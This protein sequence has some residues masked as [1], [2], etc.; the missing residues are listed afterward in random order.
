[1]YSDFMYHHSDD[2]EEHKP[3]E[4]EENA[5]L[6]GEEDANRSGKEDAN[7]SGEEDTNE[8]GYKAEETNEEDYKAGEEYKPTF[9]DLAHY[10]MAVEL[11][12]YGYLDLAVAVPRPMPPQRERAKSLDLP[13]F[14]MPQPTCTSSNPDLVYDSVTKQPLDMIIAKQPRPYGSALVVAGIIHVHGE[15]APAYDKRTALSIGKT[16]FLGLRT[17]I[18]ITQGEFQAPSIQVRGFLESTTRT[19]R[20]FDLA[21]PCGAEGFRHSFERREPKDRGEMFP[22]KSPSY[23]CLNPI[24]AADDV[25]A[26]AVDMLCISIPRSE[27][28]FSLART[29]VPEM[30]RLKQEYE[31]I[32]R[33]FEQFAAL[34]NSSDIFKCTLSRPTG[35]Y[36]AMGWPDL[37]HDVFPADAFASL[38]PGGV[39]TKDITSTNITLPAADPENPYPV[40]VQIT[41]VFF[42]QD[43]RYLTLLSGVCDE[44][45]FENTRQ[46]MGAETDSFAK[47]FALPSP[48]T[49]TDA[50]QMTNYGQLLADGRPTEAYMVVQITPQNKDLLGNVGDKVTITTLGITAES[51]P[52]PNP[53]DA[54]HVTRVAT[55]LMARYEGANNHAQST[56][57][58]QHQAAVRKHNETLS[59]D[60]DEIDEIPDFDQD[61]DIFNN[62]IFEQ[63]RGTVAGF[64]TQDMANAWTRAN[65]PDTAVSSF[66]HCLWHMVLELNRAPGETDDTYLDRL[67]TWIRAHPPVDGENRHGDKGLTF[68]GRRVTPPT[69]VTLHHALYHVFRPRQPGYAK[70]YKAPYL[71]MSFPET[72]FPAKTKDFSD[73][74]FP[75]PS[76][77]KKDEDADQSVTTTPTNAITV[78]VSVK[79]ALTT[80]NHEIKALHSMKQIR[81]G[82][83]GD[84][85]WNYSRHFQSFPVMYE[86]NLFSVL[87]GLQNIPATSLTPALRHA[88]EH[89][90]AGKIIISGC[91]GS[92][93][94]TAAVTIV[95]AA[96]ANRFYPRG[97]EAQSRAPPG[98]SEE[99]RQELDEQL[100]GIDPDKPFTDDN[101][102]SVPTPVPA[103]VPVPAPAPATV[104]VPA[105]AP[106]V[107]AGAPG[108]RRGF[109][110]QAQT[111]QGNAQIVEGRRVTVLWIAPANSIADDALQRFRRKD[112]NVVRLYTFSTELANLMRPPAE[113]HA[114]LTVTGNSRQTVNRLFT[115]HRNEAMRVQ[116]QTAS[117]HNDPMSLSNRAKQHFATDPRVTMLTAFRAL[118][119]SDPHGYAV[120]REAA[121]KNAQSLL[122]DMAK[123]VSVLCCTPVAARTLGNNTDYVPS[124]I[125]A[126]E[127]GRMTECQFFVGVEHWPHTITFILGDPQQFHAVVPSKHTVLRGASGTVWADRFGPQREVSLIQRAEDN[128]AVDVYL[129]VNHR[130]HGGITDWCSRQFYRGEMVLAQQN[131]KFHPAQ[132]VILQHL[133]KYS[134]DIRMCGLFIDIENMHETKVTSS[135]SSSTSARYCVELA[136]ALWRELPLPRKN[137]PESRFRILIIT[138]YAVQAS[139]MRYMVK[140]ISD[141]CVA[142]GA[143]EV[144]TVDDS[145]SHEA[146]ITIVDFP[147]KSGV[148]FLD[149][150]KRMTV[151]SSRA[152]YCTIYVGHADSF[153]RSPL[154]KSLV[155]WH[156]DSL[157]LLTIPTPLDWCARCFNYGHTARTCKERLGAGGLVCQSCDQKD[158]AHSGRDCRRANQS[159]SFDITETPPVLD[160]IIRDPLSLGKPQRATDHTQRELNVAH[161]SRAW[162]PGMKDDNNTATAV[163]LINAEFV[164][165][166]LQPILID[167]TEEPADDATENVAAPSALNTFTVVPLLEQAIIM[168]TATDG[169]FGKNPVDAWLRQ[170]NAAAADNHEPPV[171]Q[172]VVLDF[173]RNALDSLPPVPANDN[174]E[175]NDDD[176]TPA[177]A[178]GNSGWSNDN[179][180]APA[181]GNSGWPN[182]NT[183]APADGNT[184]WSNTPSAPADDNTWG[185]NANANGRDNGFGNGTV[186]QW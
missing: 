23:S 34:V 18:I 163:E 132:L 185:T 3:P 48:W 113:S 74:C 51:H 156:K 160:N 122:Q 71:K 121:T 52:Q 133:R 28:R 59:P 120:Q 4:G 85:F 101:L 12:S 168:A 142:P 150:P 158:K 42:G 38:R 171:P 83:D 32:G 116:E 112:V 58:E 118:Y 100:D 77:S 115:E 140:R 45:R 91:P 27:I 137:D 110:L 139:D 105:P 21:I 36:T 63:M 69:G 164:L 78:Q 154:L 46:Q 124:M 39:S 95:M 14:N 166:L 184:S 104:P 93:K 24:P 177:P 29:F 161:D 31:P 86:R 138:G 26:E 169:S 176:N 147:R 25:P 50:T 64:I 30:Y 97:Q 65:P 37:T 17:T 119:L 60:E 40:P 170:V 19:Y 106:A 143:I 127:T 175:W 53:T 128:N 152:N 49:E 162:L 57:Y 130:A 1:M 98:L 108:P 134:P 67:Q 114:V 123:N 16:F 135:W 20:V 22:A 13:P 54:H 70:A 129:R 182:D 155:A 144:R 43:H 56:V 107:P 35:S 15:M 159:A 103:T 61:E 33:N 90:K 44:Q 68:H 181:D 157:A 180:P 7:G 41:S 172:E 2:E 173:L 62:A 94:S 111:Q 117:A 80:S 126:D 66:G 174:G 141:N 99:T 109:V 92:G 84:A 88:L 148:G 178:D 55:D 5:N 96:L 82:S 10:D 125:I 79:P 11:P 47:F 165:S 72:E 8:E 76:Q 151:A 89:S 153:T 75:T 136:I 9:D 186:S 131:K 179:T 73:A 145:P 146:E 87:P 167:A 81:S 6:S 183:P 102:S 149:E